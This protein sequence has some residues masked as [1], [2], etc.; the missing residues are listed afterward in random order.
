M[1]IDA[2][3]RLFGKISLIDA[4]VAFIIIGLGAGFA[5]K[6]L[7]RSAAPIISGADT[8]YATFA[9]ER[10]RDF[11][12]SAVK[13][14]DIFWEQYE[15]ELGEAVRVETSIA[16]E[17]MKLD[18]G[19]AIY[20]PMEQ[21]FN[22]YVT[23]RCKGR[24]SD[25][26][27]YVGGVKQLSIGSDVRLKSN[28]I[29][30]GGKVCALSKEAPAT[31][32]ERTRPEG[33]S[34]GQAV[35]TQAAVSADWLSSDSIRVTASGQKKDIVFKAALSPDSDYA[36]GGRS[37]GQTE[38]IMDVINNAG[39]ELSDYREIS[40]QNADDSGIELNFSN[41]TTVVWLCYGDKIYADA[42]TLYESDIEASSY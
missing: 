32:Y 3:G 1:I 30:S 38:L 2:N 18:D 11:S 13:P 20:A 40:S 39:A 16:K 27:Y 28:M 36:E 17:I 14:G 34:F 15:R 26:G 7:S 25:S 24:V 23:L 4:L 33:V 42:F 12:A 19:S 9:F 29:L 5:Y 41:G 22:L 37:S 35:P 21:R 8:F 10:V 31:I 6:R